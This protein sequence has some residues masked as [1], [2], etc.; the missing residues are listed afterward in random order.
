MSQIE[1]ELVGTSLYA[2]L[3]PPAPGEAMLFYLV[4]SQVQQGAGPPGQLTV[5]DA[6]Q[7]TDLGY[8]VFLNTLP[9]PN[10][11]V[12]FEIQLADALPPVGLPPVVPAHTGLVWATWSN[13]SNGSLDVTGVLDVAPDPPDAI[14]AATF[15]TPPTRGIKSLGFDKDTPITTERDGGGDIQGLVFEYP[16]QAADGGRPKSEPPWGNSVL[17]PL[18]GDLSGC[19]VFQ[20]LMNEPTDPPTTAAATLKQLFDWSLDPVRP[21]D[22]SRTRFTPTGLILVLEED[23]AGA[24][25]LRPA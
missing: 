4:P 18:S 14:V 3:P 5:D 7:G 22:S 24:F 9:E 15:I 11:Y 8:F 2:P 10:E 1:L 6:W 12:D 23:E 17:V 25:H 20:S 13:G 21:Y 19:L 16:P